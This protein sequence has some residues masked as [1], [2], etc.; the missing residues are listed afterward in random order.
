M[1]TKNLK[2]IVDGLETSIEGY[3]DMELPSDCTKQEALNIITKEVSLVSNVKKREHEM[4]VQDKEYELKKDHQYF[5]EGQDKERLKLEQKNSEHTISMQNKEFALKEKDQALREQQL[6]ID[7]QEIE[8]KHINERRDF[9]FKVATFTATSV[10]TLL[11]IIIPC[12]M[13]KSLAKTSMRYSWQ[14]DGRT[15]SEFNEFMRGVKPKV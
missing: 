4:E 9:W 6:V 7:R 14:Y 2:Q 13:Y 1:A 10:T 3:N 8:H 15:P 5:V 12:I 11:G